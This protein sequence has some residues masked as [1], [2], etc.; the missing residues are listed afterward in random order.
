VHNCKRTWRGH[1]KDFL[2]VTENS[3]SVA[4]DLKKQECRLC[5]GEVTPV[6]FGQWN[7]ARI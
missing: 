6:S 2:G 1:V 3:T 5:L 7:R 4:G